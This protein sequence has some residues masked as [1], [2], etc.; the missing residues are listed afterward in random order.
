MLFSF[1]C[2]WMNPSALPTPMPGFQKW[3]NFFPSRKIN[4]ILAPTVVFVE[5]SKQKPAE[6]DIYFLSGNQLVSFRGKPTNRIRLEG[7]WGIWDS[8]P[9]SAIRTRQE[10]AA[11]Q[12]D[13]KAEPGSHK[14]G[15]RATSVKSG[16]LSAAPILAQFLPPFPRTNTGYVQHI[17]VKKGAIGI[18]ANTCKHAD[19]TCSPHAVWLFLRTDTLVSPDGAL[20]FLEMCWKK[21]SVSLPGLLSSV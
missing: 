17:W 6:Q 11:L 19:V 9:S 13:I 12:H 18:K 16:H 3:P 7:G 1:L 5:G 20:H 2:K 10:S 8:A 15:N 4:L 14:L 21:K